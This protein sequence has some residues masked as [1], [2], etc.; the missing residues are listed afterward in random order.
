MAYSQDFADS[1][2]RHL[3]AAIYLHDDREPGTLPG[4]RAVA[5]YLFGLAG[6]LAL[7]KMMLDSGMRPR[8]NARKR[9]DPFFVHFPNLKTLLRDNAQGR[10]QGQLIR[11]ANDA[12]LFQ[13][14]D[15]NMRYAPTV[16]IGD[17]RTKEWRSQAE[18]L[19]QD[20]NL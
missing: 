2:R 14:W 11:H 5:G 16:D 3:C 12:K 7:K 10:R 4:N 20:M 18:K 17:L 8:N 6:E 19:V 15:T 1:A 9:D 13:D